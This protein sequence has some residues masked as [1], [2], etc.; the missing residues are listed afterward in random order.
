MF[1]YNDELCRRNSQFLT[2]RFE[3][4]KESPNVDYSFF[5]FFLSIYKVNMTCDMITVQVQE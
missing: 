3:G 2:S 1:I 5:D 4:G